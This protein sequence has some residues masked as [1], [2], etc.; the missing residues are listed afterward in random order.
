[1]RTPEYKNNT[2][3]NNNNNENK[4]R[5]KKQTTMRHLVIQKPTAKRTLCNRPVAAF[6][7]EQALYPDLALSVDVRHHEFI[8]K[9][10]KGPPW[11][12]VVPPSALVLVPDKPEGDPVA[13]AHG[14][15]ISRRTRITKADITDN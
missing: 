3:T 1:M 7:D 10:V 14:W 12:R 4:N 11:L 13:T 6:P 5:N 15:C 9:G 8:D 2:H